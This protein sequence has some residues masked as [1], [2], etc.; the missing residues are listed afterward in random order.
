[1]LSTPPCVFLRFSTLLS[2]VLA[3][4]PASAAD[5]SEAPPTWSS[6]LAPEAAPALAQEAAAASGAKP[7]GPWRLSPALGLPKWLKLG[8][9]QRTRYEAL[10]G[11]FRAATPG[12]D[13]LFALRTTLRADLDFSPVV[14]SFEL[15]DSRQY[16]IDDP[17][18][19]NTTVVDA[20]ELIQYWAGLRFGG[21]DEGLV[22]AG[23]HTMDIGTRR[24]VARNRFRNTTNTFT[25]LNAT[26]DD[27]SG[28]SARAFAVVPVNRLP[29]DAD[30][31]DDNEIELDEDAE[32]TW[33][34]G[35]YASTPDLVSEVAGEV[36]WFYL[37]ESDAPGEAT[38]DRSL[39]TPGLRVWKEPAETQVDF[40]VEAAYQFGDSR[41]TTSG[42]DTT[43]L[44]HQAHTEHVEVGYS[45]E[46][47][48]STRLIAQFDHASG[49]RDPNDGD[50]ERFDLLF[51]ARRFDFGPTGIFGPFARSNIMSPGLR[52]FFQPSDRVD[53]M[54]VDR[55]YWLASDTDAWT[56]A[57]VR[58]P[59]GQSGDYLGNMPE[60]QVRWH[61]VPKNILVDTGF[62]YLFQGDFPEDAPNA[63]GQ[64]DSAFAYLEVTFTF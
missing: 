20:V 1:M 33:F 63:N 11:D 49:D 9:T 12:D 28:A 51:G 58:D 24:L 30:S 31:L 34:Y 39:H 57:G 53:V 22:L 55:F 46:S 21:G 8:G 61:A 27:G 2:L 19:L 14:A 40:E 4:A 52:L 36:Y 59:S 41:A 23:R 29:T 6:L 43:D 54:L 50:N 7:K 5:P 56:T 3:A 10:W 37:D 60:L 25:G 48:W 44:D 16:G 42:S 38:R 35:L 13:D 32:D 18:R 45:F 17:A 15:M 47:E 62:A 26:W 64:G